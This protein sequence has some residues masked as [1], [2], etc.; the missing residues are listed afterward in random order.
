LLG[1]FLLQLIRQTSA[2]LSYDCPQQSIYM[3]WREAAQH[4]RH[5][6]AAEEFKV[7]YQSGARILH[8]RSPLPKK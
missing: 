4:A 8:D 1:G 3:A 5:R 2:L 7:A 6:V